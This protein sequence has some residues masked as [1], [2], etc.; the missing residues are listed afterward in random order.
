MSTRSPIDNE[1][2]GPPGCV[3]VNVPD[4]DEAAN[5]IYPIVVPFRFTFNTTTFEEAILATANDP[6]NI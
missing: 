2:V 5:V 4:V 3:D 1:N 6:V